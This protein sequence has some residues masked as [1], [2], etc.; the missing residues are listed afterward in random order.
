M[1]QDWKQFEETLAEEFRGEVLS[2]E[3]RAALVAIGKKL[4]STR[5]D[6]LPSE[7][8]L[9]RIIAN[10]AK[11][12]LPV[13]S[14]ARRRSLYGDNG[15]HQFFLSSLSTLPVLAKQLFSHKRIAF[16]SSGALVL[17]LIVAASFSSSEKT[18][19]ADGQSA[20]TKILSPFVTE[21]RSED[22]LKEEAGSEK[23]ESSASKT[24]LAAASKTDAGTS[25]EDDL[26]TLYALSDSED[27]VLHSFDEGNEALQDM[28][29]DIISVNKL[30]DETSF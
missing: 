29:Q 28:D 14:E 22:T 26:A 9:E 16:A 23:P 15:V 18:S 7:A 25:L 10:E 20:W 6:A 17:L 8:L 4:A 2:I 11:R 13:T 12:P 1:K 19:V 30:Y 3:E 21:M 5:A 27:A 24:K